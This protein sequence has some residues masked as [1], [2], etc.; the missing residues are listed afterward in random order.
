MTPAW[1]IM[2]RCVWGVSVSVGCVAC[3]ADT[4]SEHDFTPDM[5]DAFNGQ[6]DLSLPHEDTGSLYD[7]G[8][9]DLP[10]A[11]IAPLDLGVP[12]QDVPDQESPDLEVFADMPEEDFAAS[13]GPWGDGV[14][15]V[16]GGSSWGDDAIGIGTGKDDL[17]DVVQGSLSS[18][19]AGP[20]GGYH[21]WVG[22]ALDD[23]LIDH[24]TE[25]QLAVLPILYRIWLH[26][27]TLLA[28]TQRLGGLS[29]GAD[30][31]QVSVGQYAV[32]EAPIRPRRMDGEQ[33]FYRVDISLPNEQQPRSRTVWLTSQCCD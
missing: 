18:W 6:V 13:S 25:E 1:K 12:D 17:E 23:D 2:V 16:P 4:H 30:E 24:L 14:E 26:D 5:S 15:Q 32:L 33:L 29:R 20:Q 19:E 8:S 27:G 22:C 10:D 9:A 21:I 7:L 31:R 11:F 28:S 3:Q